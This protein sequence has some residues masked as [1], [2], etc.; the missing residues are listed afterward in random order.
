MTIA[1][2]NSPASG[3]ISPEDHD[4]LIGAIY[5]CVIDPTGWPAVLARICAAVGGA[6]AWIAVHYPGQIRS[7][8]EIEVGTDPEQQ[9]RLRTLYVAAS[10]FI[11]AVHYVARADILSVADAVDYDEFQAGRFYREWAEPQGWHDFIL[12]VLAREADRFTWLGICMAERVQ[13]EHKARVAGLLPHVERAVRISDLLKLRTDQAADLAAMAEGLATGMILVDGAAEVRG[14]NAAA[15]QLIS[16]HPELGLVNGRLRLPADAAGTAIRAAIQACAEA[17]QEASGAT[18]LIEDEAGEGLLVH[19]MPLTPPQ[20][21][22]S[23]AA[24][25][26]LFLTDPAAPGRAP[27]D[28]FVTRYGLTPSETRVLVA[29]LEGKNPRAIAAAQGVAMPTVRTHLRRIYE[30]TGAA[31]QADVVRLV[32]GMSTAL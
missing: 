22:R 18:V 12:G 8:Y 27:V 30:K 14:V 17:R 10:P 28:A 15:R 26:A 7:I 31:G 25:A 19:V 23:G 5:E 20:D 4:A 21:G 16:S 32:A 11:G 9:Q 24:V 13:P 2:A 3:Q 29:L 1:T 6:A